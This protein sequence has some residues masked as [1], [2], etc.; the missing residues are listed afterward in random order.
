MSDD[1]ENNDDFVDYDELEEMLDE[2][3]EAE[4]NENWHATG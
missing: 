2:L 1:S 4:N 3:V